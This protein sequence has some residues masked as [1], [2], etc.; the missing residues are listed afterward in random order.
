MADLA[1]ESQCFSCLKLHAFYVQYCNHIVAALNSPMASCYL[2][3][4]RRRRSRAD[5]EAEDDGAEDAA[6]QEHESD[7]PQ[8]E[9]TLQQGEQSLV[10]EVLV[11]DTSELPVTSADEQL[12][13]TGSHADSD[14]EPTL[15]F[16]HDIVDSSQSDGDM[17][18][19]DGS[20][21]ETGTLAGDLAQWATASNQTLVLLMVCRA[22]L[23]DMVI[24]FPKMPGLFSKLQKTFS[25]SSSAMVNMPIM[26]WSLAFL[27]S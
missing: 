9:T 21:N 18:E 11:D 22:F 16:E 6:A 20:D 15:E 25:V 2:R 26:V 19:A 23:E 7:E 13:A 14:K 12:M 27:T 8:E 24:V 5:A 1:I 10:E 4:W 3:E 17:A